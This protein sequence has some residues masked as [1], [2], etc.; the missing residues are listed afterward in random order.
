MLGVYG[1]KGAASR[2]EWD[3]FSKVSES[4]SNFRPGAASILTSRAGAKARCGA[5]LSVPWVSIRSAV[6]D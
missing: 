4:G 5:S 1:G 3:K 6:L 2:T